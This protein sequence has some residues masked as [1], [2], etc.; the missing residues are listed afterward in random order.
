[1]P[2]TIYYEL[3]TPIFSD[4][5]PTD[6]VQNPADNSISKEWYIPAFLDPDVDENV[7]NSADNSISKEWYIPL[8]ADPSYAYDITFP[9]P[10]GKYASRA[11]Q[12]VLIGMLAQ[13]HIFPLLP[14]RGFVLQW[15]FKLVSDTDYATPVAGKTGIVVKYSRDGQA[16]I[17]INNPVT[18][19]SDGWYSVEITEEATN[20]VGNT[21]VLMATVSGCAQCDEL[22]QF[23]KG[24]SEDI[25]KSGIA[26]PSIS[27]PL[28]TE[29][30]EVAP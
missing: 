12:Q 8:F 11:T 21:L 5:T 30:I 19:I 18:E 1:M 15:K 13:R 14:Q 6:A 23:Y 29:T 27:Q 24:T 3:N 22:M 4:P 2:Y 28:T 7:N 16:F 17:T 9:R 10:G 26:I 25:T 20:V